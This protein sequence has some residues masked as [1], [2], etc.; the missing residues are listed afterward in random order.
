MRRNTTD[1]A[2]AAGEPNLPAQSEYD[3]FLEDARSDKRKGFAALMF[4]V[5][6]TA[7]GIGLVGYRI[8][9]PGPAP[10]LAEMCRGDVLA[11][12][13]V[14]TPAGRPRLEDIAEDLNAW[15][16]GAR[17]VSVDMDF[18]RRQAWRTYALTRGGSQADNV[19]KTYHETNRPDE[20]AKSK[21]VKLDG[22]TAFPAGGDASSNTW[23]LEWREI[24]RGRDG[25]VMSVTNWRMEASFIVKPPTTA[26]ELRRNP[27]GIYVEAFKWEA[28]P[29]GQRARVAE[30]GR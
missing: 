26:D 27:H 25:T 22:Q 14:D 23:R 17:E 4:G 24:T 10:L 11:V 20:L 12:R 30:A 15:V 3:S 16:R 13:S 8:V 18:L 5:A 6:F 19:L 21:T 2:I 1:T 9:V 7:A 28:V 29:N